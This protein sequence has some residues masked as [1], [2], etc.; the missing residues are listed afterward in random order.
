MTPSNSAY[1]IPYLASSRF[2]EISPRI[3]KGPADKGVMSPAPDPRKYPGEAYG[4]AFICY[5]D[6]AVNELFEHL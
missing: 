4:D 6:G 3:V 2:R 1:I 5:V